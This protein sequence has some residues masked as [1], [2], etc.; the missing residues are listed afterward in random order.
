MRYPVASAFLV[1]IAWLAIQRGHPQVVE[2][3]RRRALVRWAVEGI[4]SVVRKDANLLGL[5]AY[6]AVINRGLPNRQIVLDVSR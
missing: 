5:W 4:Q 3:L 1:G 2:R 6:L